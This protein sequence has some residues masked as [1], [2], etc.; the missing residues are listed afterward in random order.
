MSEIDMTEF[1]EYQIDDFQE[2]KIAVICNY[3]CRQPLAVKGKCPL[4]EIL[5]YLRQRKFHLQGNGMVCRDVKVVVYSSSNFFIASC[6]EAE[7]ADF[8]LS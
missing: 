6:R 3:I 1:M 4:A 2:G 5:C 8:H 7:S